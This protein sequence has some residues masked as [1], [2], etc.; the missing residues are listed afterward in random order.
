MSRSPLPARRATSS[1][2]PSSPQARVVALLDRYSPSWTAEL[3]E[4]AS[5]HSPDS[6]TLLKL[7]RVSIDDV[8]A[9][10]SIR[11]ESAS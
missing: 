3:P 2:R 9:R 5:D 7:M 8:M 10:Q 6:T 1:A 4:L 11:R